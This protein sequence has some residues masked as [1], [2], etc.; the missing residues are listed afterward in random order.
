[1]RS[2]SCA[3][4]A[5]QNTPLVVIFRILRCDA[6]ERRQTGIIVME[7]RLVNELRAGNTTLYNWNRVIGRL[8]FFGGKK[9]HEYATT[10]I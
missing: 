3:A 2:P 1:M 8:R 10:T 7:T 4:L 9:I 6:S 5:R